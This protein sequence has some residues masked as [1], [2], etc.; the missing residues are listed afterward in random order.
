[1]NKFF[2]TILALALCVFASCSSDNDETQGTDAN[3]YKFSGR[4]VEVVEKECYEP[5]KFVDVVSHQT[6][7]NDYVGIWVV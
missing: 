3:N 2:K 4:L 5:Q 6:F 1:M 7:I